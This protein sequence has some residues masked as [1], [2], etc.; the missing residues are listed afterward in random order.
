[1]KER[2]ERVQ[3]EQPTRTQQHQALLN[4]GH[5]TEGKVLLAPLL[6]AWVFLPWGR[7]GQIYAWMQGDDPGWSRDLLLSSASQLC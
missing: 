6:F 1:M 4:R 2:N 7:P 3:E 5:G